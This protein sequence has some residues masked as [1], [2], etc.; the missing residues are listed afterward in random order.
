MNVV[1]SEY[2]KI[3]LNMRFWTPLG[4]LVDSFISFYGP[5]S[6]FV[7]LCTVD[8]GHWLFFPFCSMKLFKQRMIQWMRKKT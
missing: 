7:I 5:D 4:A 2:V 8:L 3:Y 6:A 1:T